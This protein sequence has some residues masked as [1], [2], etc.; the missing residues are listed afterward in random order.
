MKYLILVLLMIGFVSAGCVNINSASL[1]EL[2]EIVWIGPATA[3]K[4]IDA[5]PF[6]DV[7]DLDK[8]SGIGDVKVGDIKAEGLACVDGKSEK[9]VEERIEEKVVENS[10][11]EEVN[12]LTD[13]PKVISL[14]MEAAGEID[15][16]VYVSKNAKVFGWLPYGF[17]LFLIFII[18]ILLWERF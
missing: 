8:V 13:E 18:C 9:E 3:Q 10:T 16:L 4:I 5:R 1:E 12:L 17:A 2:D 6:D 7:D 14:N 11:K 15:E